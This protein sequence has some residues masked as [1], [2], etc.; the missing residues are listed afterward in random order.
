M[1]PRM[2]PEAYFTGQGRKRNVEVVDLAK[3]GMRLHRMEKMTDGVERRQLPSDRGTGTFR[4]LDENQPVGVGYDHAA[5]CLVLFLLHSHA[6][7]FSCLV[8]KRPR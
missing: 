2:A 4:Y 7:L 5:P 1:Q 3:L 6:A 8:L